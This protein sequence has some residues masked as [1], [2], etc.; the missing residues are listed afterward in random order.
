MVV[1][2]RKQR[3]AIKSARNLIDFSN[4]GLD[5]EVLDHVKAQPDIEEEIVFE[6]SKP[7]Q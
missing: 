5:T 2:A 7:R 1:I 4:I 6:D 3:L